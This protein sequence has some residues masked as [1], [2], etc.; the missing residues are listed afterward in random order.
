[1]RLA[2]LRAIATIALIL[3][4][5]AAGARGG[6]GGH[7]KT[8]DA[9]SYGGGWTTIACA[10]TD[11]SAAF[12]SFQTSAI[13]ANPALA[14][15]RVTGTCIL[16]N[17]ARLFTRGIRNLIVWAY[18][19]SFSDVAMGGAGFAGDDSHT[20]LIQTVSA[21]A[22]TVTLITLADASKFDVGGIV[23][24]AANSLQNE[25]YP[26]NFQLFEFRVVTAKNAGTGVITLS[27]ALSNTYL[28]TYP[29][30]LSNGAIT[31][32]P[33]AIYQMDASFDINLQWFGGHIKAPN[34]W[35]VG[36]KNTAVYD[37]E[38][39]NPIGIGT[40]Q[41][42]WFFFD[43]LTGPTGGAE[44]DK[45]IDLLGIIRSTGQSLIFQSASIN[46]AL[47]EGSSFRA[48]A[49]SMNGTPKNIR[50]N[51]STFPT[52]KVGPL[53]YGA[54]VSVA[55]DGVSVTSPAV[56][57]PE[58]PT[59]QVSYSSGTFSQANASGSIENFYEVFVPGHKY[60][61]GYHNSGICSPLYVFTVSALTQDVTNSYAS[62][63][64]WT[65]DGSPIS[66]PAAIPTPTCNNGGTFNTLNS[67]PAA[68]ITQ[69]FTGPAD[70]TQFAAPP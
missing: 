54:G 52:F 26:P 63:S 10:G 43:E 7:N 3:I 69:K 39:D 46:S 65:Q 2:A 27:S 13:A 44:V 23:C 70:L 29:S 28:S 24:I 8:F 1:M 51:N 50:V 40:A 12:E 4:A 58:I 68:T 16:D 62:T 22:T 18:G 55:L 57:N 30:M 67:Y 38:A 9:S 25:G 34:A 20:G 14:K 5:G 47:V 6:G 66:T 56:A 59:S 33:A 45:Q 32:G 61:M 15:L 37:I 31:A 35:Q 11:D 49:L 19:S 17:T 64:S 36:G 42:S 21:G 53:V 60:W 48:A 41:T